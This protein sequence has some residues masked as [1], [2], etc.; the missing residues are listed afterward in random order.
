MNSLLVPRR[1]YNR[2][3]RNFRAEGRTVPVGVESVALQVEHGVNHVLHYLRPRDRTRLRHVPHDEHC[4]AG[5]L[6]QP[7]ESASA[8]FNLR[9]QKRCNN[10]M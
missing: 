1:Q 4:N 10:K 6:R 2:V 5:A 3:R 9:R 7:D 8:L